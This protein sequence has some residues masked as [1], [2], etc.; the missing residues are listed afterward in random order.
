MKILRAINVPVMYYEP[1]RFIAD[2]EPL[3][4]WVDDGPAYC[5]EHDGCR[6]MR[7]KLF[8][9]PVILDVVCFQ[10]DLETLP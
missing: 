4:E 8:G 9:E 2:D 6:L 7:Y 10:V 3:G 5:E 1:L